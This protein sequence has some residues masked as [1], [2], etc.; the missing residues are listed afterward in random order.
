MEVTSL[1][2]CLLSAWRAFPE[3]LRGL[4]D[5]WSAEVRQ[6]SPLVYRG[7]G[8]TETLGDSGAPALLTQ[9]PRTPLLLTSSFFALKNGNVGGAEATD[10]RRVS[11]PGL[12]DILDQMIYCCPVSLG[13]GTFGSICP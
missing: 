3:T 10:S 5:P 9:G 6:L 7:Q 2:E 1:I 11:R 13:C 8:G 4:V 12:C